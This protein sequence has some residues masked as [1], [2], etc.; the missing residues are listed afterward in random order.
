MSLKLKK[1]SKAALRFTKKKKK[2]KLW[3]RRKP[4]PAF[5][6]DEDFITDG[7]IKNWR[8]PYDAL[9]YLKKRFDRGDMLGDFLKAIATEKLDM[10]N[11]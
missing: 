4:E 6:F 7:L 3:I 5:N 10:Q 2:K 11:A 1:R 8:N 9:S